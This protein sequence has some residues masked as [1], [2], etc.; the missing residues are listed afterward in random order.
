LNPSPAF[1]GFIA[2]AA[3]SNVLE[4]QIEAQ[5]ASFKPPH[6]VAAMVLDSARGMDTEEHMTTGGKADPKKKE[7]GEETKEATIERLKQRIIQLESTLKEL[8]DEATVR[9][10]VVA[11]ANSEQRAVNGIATS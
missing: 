5:L 11:K 7:E 1:I 10:K 3:G 2:A 8:Q 6:P 9:E 4:E